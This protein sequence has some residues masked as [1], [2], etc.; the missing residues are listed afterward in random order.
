MFLNPFPIFL[1]LLYLS[2]GPDRS[3]HSR[4]LGIPIPPDYSLPKVLSVYFRFRRLLVLLVLDTGHHV[5]RNHRV[6]SE[7]DVGHPLVEQ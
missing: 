7:E 5:G 6:V 1:V 3:R 4:I 2:L